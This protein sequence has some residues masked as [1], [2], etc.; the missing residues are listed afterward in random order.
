MWVHWIWL[1]SFSVLLVIPYCILYSYLQYVA[2]F[3]KD[4]AVYACSKS[5]VLATSAE[6]QCIHTHM[7]IVSLVHSAPWM[8]CN[9]LFVAKPGQNPV[10]VLKRLFNDYGS[11]TMTLSRVVVK[12]C[13]H[14]HLGS[15]SVPI[16]ES[17]M[18]PVGLCPEPVLAGEALPGPQD[19]LLWHRPLPL[20]RHDWV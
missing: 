10:C 5:L 15:F 13:N 6:G 4:P 8:I 1:F 2:V 20:L 3:V 12:V 19:S 11:C 9:E 7:I 14:Y 16:V 18:S 17:V